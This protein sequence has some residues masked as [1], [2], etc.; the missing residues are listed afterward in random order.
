M[1][2]T[3]T[4]KNRLLILAPAILMLF[5]GKLIENNPI[6]AFAIAIVSSLLIRY[7]EK[8]IISSATS[9]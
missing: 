4:V 1:K 5:S 8:K 6:S 7:V 2:L 3:K 9:E